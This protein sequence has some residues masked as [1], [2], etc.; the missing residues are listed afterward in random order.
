MDDTIQYLN[1]DLELVSDDDLTALAA[2]FEAKGMFPL[3]GATQEA[4]GLWYA[5]FEMEDHFNEEM[6]HFNEEPGLTIASMLAVIESLTGPLQIAW[7]RCTL[8]EFNIGYDCG[9]KPWAFNQGLS[10]GLLARIAAAGASLRWTLYPERPE[11]K[12]AERSG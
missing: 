3:Y 7:S 8:R 5:K 1:T 9:S 4:D 10:N 2:A 12:E 6:D 11:S